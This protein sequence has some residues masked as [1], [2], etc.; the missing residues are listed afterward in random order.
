MERMERRGAEDLRHRRER[1]AWRSERLQAVSPHLRLV[2]CG[3][4]LSLL[5]DRLAVV[6]KNHLKR[7]T[8]HW[9]GIDTHLQALNPNAVLARGYSITRTL[10]QGVV[11]RNPGDLK[12][13]QR[14]EI[15]V[16]KGR[17]TVTVDSPKDSLP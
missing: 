2:E 4:R 16:A 17:F 13:D 8:L 6:L 1:L 10:P 15:T 11:V 9:H 12:M 14:L 7:K 3:R 5:N